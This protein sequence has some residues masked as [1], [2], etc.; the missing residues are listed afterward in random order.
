MVRV[1]FLAAAMCLLASCSERHRW[2][3]PDR[4]CPSVLRPVWVADS[5]LTIC[6]LTSFRTRD[7]QTWTR[8][9]GLIPQDSFDI[10][11]TVGITESALTG[12]WPSSLKTSSS[13]ATCPAVDSIEVHADTI[14]GSAAHTEVGRVASAPGGTSRSYAFVSSWILDEAHRVVARGHASTRPTLDTLLMILRSAERW[15]APTQ[16]KP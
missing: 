8:G 13:C 5:S 15:T 7:L 16:R 2:I 12:G 11:T 4:D 6:V 1:P 14:A 10:R 3:P 9:D